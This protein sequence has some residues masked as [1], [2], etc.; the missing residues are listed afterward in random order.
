MKGLTQKQRNILNFVEDFM[1][2]EG[3]APTVYEIA[4]HFGTKTSTIFAHLRA[5]QKKNYLSRSSKARSI[6]LLR[7]RKKMRRLAGLRSIP[8]YDDQTENRSYYSG[9]QYKLL[10]D[11]SI[12]SKTLHSNSRSLFAVRVHG[13]AMKEFGIFDGDIAIVKRCEGPF[14]RGDIVVMDLEDGQ[15]ALRS[16]AGISDEKMELVDSKGNMETHLIKDIPVR[17]LVIGLQRAF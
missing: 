11:S 14:K 17:G 6:S 4:E 9:A 2:R 7:S 10:C 12:F 13:T 5:L 8:V 15:S 16:C 1:D 3:M